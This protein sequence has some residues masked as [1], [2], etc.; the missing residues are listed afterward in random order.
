MVDYLVESTVRVE[1]ERVRVTSSLIRVR[2]QRQVWSKSYD[3]QPTSI[4][5]LQRDLSG[6]IADEIRRQLSPER[7]SALTRRQP[8]NAEAYFLYLRGRGF[9][10]EATPTANVR[11]IQY[12]ERAIV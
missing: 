11:A 1:G 5:G 12:Y 8:Q 3:R 10:N 9:S 6:A 2:D 4:L 7:L